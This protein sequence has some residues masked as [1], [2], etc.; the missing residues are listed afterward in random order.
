VNAIWSRFNHFACAKPSR[1]RA[2]AVAVILA[3]EF[4]VSGVVVLGIHT[5]GR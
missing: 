5:L 1:P 2:S 3:M 4:A